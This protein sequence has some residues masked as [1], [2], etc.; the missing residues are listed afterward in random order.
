MQVAWRDDALASLERVRAYIAERNPE[1]AGRLLAA[2]FEAVSRLAFAPY[3]GR[4]GRVS[5]TREL[6]MR[7]TPYIVAYTV[8]GERVVILEVRHGAREW[9]KAFDLC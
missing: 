6:V 7:R 5:G 9:P 1:A 2:V 8:D 4:R 3:L